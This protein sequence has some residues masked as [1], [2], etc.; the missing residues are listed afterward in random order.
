MDEAKVIEAIDW[1]ERAAESSNVFRRF[2]NAFNRMMARA[3]LDG[4]GADLTTIFWHVYE[5]RRNTN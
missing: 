5:S 1:I 3:T 4:I 2:R